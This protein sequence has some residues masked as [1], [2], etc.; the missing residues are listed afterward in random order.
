MKTPITFAKVTDGKVF[1][2][3]MEK[4]KSPPEVSNFTSHEN[5]EIYRGFEKAMQNFNDSFINTS[6]PDLGLIFNRLAFNKGSFSGGL[7]PLEGL[8]FEL[9]HKC[10]YMEVGGNCPDC[11]KY[12]LCSKI[13][14]VSLTEPKND[15]RVV[16]YVRAVPPRQT[17]QAFDLG[18]EQSNS[19]QNAMHLLSGV[20][21]IPEV[22][23]RMI[24]NAIEEF[25]KQHG[26]KRT[27]QHLEES[28]Q[29]KS[30][31]KKDSCE[32]IW[33]KSEQDCPED[34]S[35]M[36]YPKE[37]V[38]RIAHENSRGNSSIT[39]ATSNEIWGIAK[40][41]DGAVYYLKE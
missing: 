22:R 3:S 5:V 14:I 1:V 23:K 8:E 25:L 36:D 40:S 6:N 17:M 21:V 39:T 31:K 29:P 38:I 28:E 37:Y 27:N 16:G 41:E 35:Y 33:V 18:L 20:M 30:A 13:A 15:Q 24:Y 26:Y 7:Y 10:Q 2:T 12:S 32:W 11:F 19:L 34:D 4:P 9:E